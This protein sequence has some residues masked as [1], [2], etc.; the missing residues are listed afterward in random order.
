M[1]VEEKGGGLREQIPLLLVVVAD[2]KTCIGGVDRNQ[3][4][5]FVAGRA[6]T[7]ARPS[8]DVL[9]LV[10]DDC[11]ERTNVPRRGRADDLAIC[12]PNKFLFQ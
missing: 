11:L 2:Q 6:E 7:F 10:P 5:M 4:A 12:I 8:D 1:R 3:L 9:V